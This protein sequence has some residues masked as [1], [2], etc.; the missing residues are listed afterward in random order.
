MRFLYFQFPVWLVLSLLLSLP[1]YAQ[2]TVTYIRDSEIENML[3]V[4]IARIKPD[5]PSDSVSIRLVLDR[6]VNAYVSGG[7]NIFIHTGL[8]QFARSPEEVMGVLAHEFGH[9][10][11]GHLITLSKIHDRAQTQSIATTLIAVPLAIL[12]GSAGA[13]AAA[14]TGSTSAAQRIALAQLRALESSADQYSVRMLKDAQISLSGLISLNQRLQAQKAL[15][16]EGDWYLSSH[17]QSSER[18]A[19]LQE[20]LEKQE[21]AKALADGYAYA[22]ARVRAKIDGYESPPQ[23]IARRYPLDDT[24]HTDPWGE[25]VTYYAHSINALKHKY[26]DDALQ[27]AAK[28]LQ[29]RPNDPFYHELKADI[30][31]AQGRPNLALEHYATT[32]QTIAWAVPVRLVRARM[33]LR[34][35]G[36]ENDADRRG[37]LRMMLQD[38]LDEITAQERDNLSAWRAYI[39][40]YEQIGDVG[41]AALARAKVALLGGDAKRAEYFADLAITTLQR[42][43]P[44]WQHAHDIKQ[45]ARQIHDDQG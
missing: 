10:E 21:D 23:Q 27:F 14:I 31:R 9:I 36:G 26:F 8:L 15:Y 1:A 20:A 7:A 40:L 43:S 35:L 39:G 44:A 41:K 29:M 33:L 37:D 19:T 12:A 45:S 22:L 2:G 17:P 24:T 13:G 6:Q 3:R 16:G 4:F 34:M 42:S 5:I 38:D 11:A 28:L 30:Y 32:L 18:I 25:E